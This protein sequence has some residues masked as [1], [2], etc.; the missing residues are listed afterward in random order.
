M[1]FNIYDYICCPKCKS[2]LS[3]TQSGLHC[4][5]CGFSTSSE[6]DNCFK[7]ISEDMYPQEERDLMGNVAQFWNSGRNKRLKE[8]EHD[9]FTF[10]EK[11]RVKHH[12]DDE[13]KVLQKNKYRLYVYTI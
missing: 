8:E 12:Y 9:L 7:M 13:F 1:K 4:N 5:V 2:E 3:K 6:K 11:E 10:K